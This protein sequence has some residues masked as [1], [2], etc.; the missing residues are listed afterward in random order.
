MEDAQIIRV[1]YIALPEIE[2]NRMLLCKE[3][4]SI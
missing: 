1:L 3:V 4:Q 2:R